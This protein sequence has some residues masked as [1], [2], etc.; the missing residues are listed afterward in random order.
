MAFLI[1]IGPRG[2]NVTGLIL[3]LAGILLLFRYGMPYRTRDNGV[4]Y[5]ITSQIDQTD[6]K[7][8]RLYDV[9]GWLGLAFVIIGT[10]CQIISNFA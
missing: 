7:W 6:L 10:A 4:Q 9:L 2:W 5:I 1:E 3:A 8:E